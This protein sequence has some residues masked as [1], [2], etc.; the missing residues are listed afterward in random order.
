MRLVSPVLVALALV[1]ALPGFAGTDQADQADQVDQVD[2]AD[3][4]ELIERI[5]E[6]DARK[7][8]MAVGL[9]GARVSHPEVLSGTIGVLWARHPV[10]F[11]CTTGC[12]H[13]GL[14]VELNPGIAGAQAGIGYGILVGDKGTNKFFVRKAYIG[15]SF[16]G[17]FLR[18]WGNGSIEPE[19]QSFLGA[20]GQFTF[21]QLNL[22][23]GLLRS[24]AGADAGDR[25]LVTGGLG[26]GF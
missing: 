24:L 1:L 8:T 11:D 3:Q 12:G 14:M 22:R 25:W 18:T 6:Y 20:E 19:Q 7:K 2:Q 26:W 23:L 5:R 10:D 16:M 15:W 9:L 4:D 21:S 17:K 13:R